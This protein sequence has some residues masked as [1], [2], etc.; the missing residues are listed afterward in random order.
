MFFHID[1][2]GNTGNNLFDSNQPI[3][4]YGVLSSKLNVDALGVQIHRQM[5]KKLGEESLHA[6]QLG[7]EKLTG[8]A[9]LLYQLQKKL[10][11][12]FDYY[13]IEKQTYA[14]VTFF[15]SVFDAGINPAVKW[16]VYWTPQRYYYIHLLAPFFDEELLKESW[17]LFIER[18]ISRN[19]DRISS[20]LSEL[21]TR[22]NS[23]KM[24]PRPKELI[25]DTLH[26]GIREPLTLDFGTADQKI[27]SPNSVGFQFVVSSMTDRLRGNGRKDAMSIVV[28]RQSQFN[29]AQIRTHSLSQIFA[30]SLKRASPKERRWYINHPLHRDIP[31]RS[32][33]CNGAPVKSISVSNSKNS[34]GLQICDTYLWIIIRVFSDKPISEEL[35]YIAGTLLKRSMIDSISMEGMAY[36][37]E[38]F[39]RQ[40]PR[41]EDVPQEIIKATEAKIEE[42]RAKVR[43]IEL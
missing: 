17:S 38:N 28:D 27:V 8:I 22:I 24:H 19:A 36:R 3:L 35:K 25:G 32:V 5:L 42:H 20:L 1:E 16:D 34:I 10:K 21:L 41:L 37:W 6:N 18:N 39:E 11:F 13:F 31:E 26:Y 43:S 30:A 9:P 14:L 7:V 29:T 40:L 4:S 12:D 15:D 23:S 33:T 2:S